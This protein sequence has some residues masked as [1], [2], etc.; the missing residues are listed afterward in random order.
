MRQV[1][2]DALEQIE[3]D[4][5]LDARVEEVSV[6]NKQLIANRLAD[7][8]LAKTYHAGKV[9]VPALR[10][11]SIV[12]EH[13][14]GEVDDGD[15]IRFSGRASGTMEPLIDADALLARIAG[16]PVSEAQAILDGL[17]QA[18]VNVWPGFLG[19]LPNDRERITLD[20]L[21]ASATE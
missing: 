7:I 20:V 19:D 13:E 4:I 16:L 12:V 8:A 14:P 1:A 11:A 21:E 6:A 5:P 2:A 15:R 10:D 17:G 18:T 9:D 3:V